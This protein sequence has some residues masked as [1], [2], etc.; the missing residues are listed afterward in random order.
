MCFRKLIIK[1]DRGDL[2]TKG[3]RDEETKRRRDK[4]IKR[5]IIIIT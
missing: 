4:R 2:K 1:H 3:R 5:Y